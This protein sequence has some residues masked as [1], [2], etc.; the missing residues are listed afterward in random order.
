VQGHPAEAAAHF[1][2]ALRQRPN[3]VTALSGLAWTLATTADPDVRDA[4]AAM[5]AGER[6]AEL[7][8]RQDPVALDSLAAAYAAAGRFDDAQ[9]QGRLARQLAV[10]A[11]ATALAE[12]IAGRLAL[13]EQRQPFTL[14]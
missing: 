11:G 12:D 4:A 3:L 14:K 2:E 9:A 7:T 5:T 8:R 6:A 1:R 13:Y 10:A